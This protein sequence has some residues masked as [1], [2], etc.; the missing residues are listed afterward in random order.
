MV[1]DVAVEVDAGSVARVLDHLAEDQGGGGQLLVE[2]VLG[3][4]LLQRLPVEGYGHRDLVVL[5]EVEDE[6]RLLRALY[7]ARGLGEEVDAD[8]EPRVDGALHVLLELL[9]HEELALGGAAVAAAYHGELD[10]GVR[11]GLPVDVAL[12]EGD[13]DAEPGLV[14]VA[15]VDGD[16]VLAG[17]EVV[18]GE[19]GDGHALGLIH[20][21]LTGAG[22]HIDHALVRVGRGLRVARA[23]GGQR[24]G[25]HAQEEGGKC[26]F[27]VFHCLVLSYPTGF[28][29]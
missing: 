12:V 18:G 2:D 9:V 27:E 17:L 4:R 7:G 21:L 25:R 29:T 5:D 3:A 24:Q 11:H 1:G 13:V 26:F 19:L 20:P 23:A 8:V 15:G 10:A 14:E 28:D 22:V 6:Q 16:A